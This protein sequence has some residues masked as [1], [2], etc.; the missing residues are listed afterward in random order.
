MPRAG[1]ACLVA[2][3]QQIVAI[4]RLDLVLV[5]QGNAPGDPKCAARYVQMVLAAIENGGFPD[6]PVPNVKV[7][8]PQAFAR[9][10]TDGDGK[11]SAAEFG[12]APIA[13]RQPGLFNRLDTDGYLSAQEA[14]SM[15]RTS[16]ALNRRNRLNDSRPALRGPSRG[17]PAP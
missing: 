8:P 12:K 4:P 14:A 17:A 16:S 3:G 11:L 13:K 1:I 7:Q 9:L 6:E 10:D 15:G 5:R 2:L